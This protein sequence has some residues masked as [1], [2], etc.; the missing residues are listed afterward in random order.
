MHEPDDTPPLPT[1]LDAL[2]AALI[3]RLQIDL[4]LLPRPFAAL[5]EEL[6]CGET[7]L[8]ARLQRLLAQGTLSRFGPMFQIERAGGRFVLA[9]IAVPEARYAEVAALVNAMPEV[10]HNYRREHALNM[11]FVLATENP[12]EIAA[13][14]A[15]IEAATGLP[16]LA[17]PKEREYHVGLYL[18]ARAEEGSHV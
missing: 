5:A 10:A 9:A 3:N 14:C 17:F 15:R 8:I 13:V 11:W 2:D 1:H 4:P 16:V 18:E 6:G 7:Q 12:A